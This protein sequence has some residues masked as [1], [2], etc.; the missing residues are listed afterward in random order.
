V[1]AAGTEG[2]AAGTEGDAAGTLTGAA[3]EV[4]EASHTKVETVRGVAAVTV[5]AVLTV[6][7]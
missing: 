2:D 7:V 1:G 4:D 3:T 6:R 5:R